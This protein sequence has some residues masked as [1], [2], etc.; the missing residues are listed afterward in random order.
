MTV[1]VLSLFTISWTIF[2]KTLHIFP[3]AK[4]GKSFPLYM[5]HS[6][7]FAKQ[8]LNRRCD[9]KRR[10]TAEYVSITPKCLSHTFSSSS[11]KPSMFPVEAAFEITWTGCQHQVAN[12]PSCKSQT[13]KHPYGQTHKALNLHREL[14]GAGDPR[15]FT[16]RRQQ[17][18]LN[19]SC[20]IQDSPGYVDSESKS[21]QISA[22]A[23]PPSSASLG[24]V[25]T[26]RSPVVRHN[27]STGTTLQQPTSRTGTELTILWYSETLLQK[28]STT[29]KHSGLWFRHTSVWLCLSG[30]LQGR[31]K[32]TISWHFLHSLSIP[33]KTLSLKG[34]E[35]LYSQRKCVPGRKL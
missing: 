22:S 31:L 7:E 30:V 35:S 28:L 34:E 14:R 10:R 20:Q 6:Y 33:D 9:N 12:N 1:T 27:F 8:H 21:Q 3:D 4:P 2:L 16:S 19:P 11:L 23:A 32:S 18:S 24:W 17:Y 15:H 26:G 29:A 25:L 5:W 13:P